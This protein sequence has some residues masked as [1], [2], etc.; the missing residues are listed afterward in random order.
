MIDFALPVK[1]GKVGGVMRIPTPPRHL[2]P[3]QVAERYAVTVP[4]VLAWMRAGIIPPKVAIGRIYRFDPVE[5]DRALSGHRL[6]GA[7][8]ES[9][10]SNPS[11]P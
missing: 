6:P 2:T 8:T 5:V 11:Q 9:E 3:R 10:I 4:T 7:S 1:M